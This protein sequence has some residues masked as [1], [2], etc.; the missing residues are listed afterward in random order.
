[1]RSLFAA[2]SIVFSVSALAATPP[3]LNEKLLREAMESHLKDS[4]SAKF[5]SVRYL[6]GDTGGLWQMC[7]EVNAKNSF[8]G[9]VGFTRFFGVVTKDSKT[10]PYYIVMAVGE[11]ADSMCMKNGF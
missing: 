10:P 2:L 4:D 8:G 7:G 3:K 1:M 6:P 11:T 9:Y 5:R